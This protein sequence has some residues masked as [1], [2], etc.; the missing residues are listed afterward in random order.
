M[1]IHCI[2]IS[3]RPAYTRLDVG[4]C[5]ITSGSYYLARWQEDYSYCR[6]TISAIMHSQN[7]HSLSLVSF[8]I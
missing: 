3:E 5:Q 6:G 8:V 1:N 4:T 2:V 7:W